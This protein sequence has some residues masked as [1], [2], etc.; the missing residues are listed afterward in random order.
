MPNHN[1]TVDVTYLKTYYAAV[2]YKMAS[3]LQEPPHFDIIESLEGLLDGAAYEFVSPRYEGL[4]ADIKVVKGNIAGKDANVTVTYRTDSFDVIV[5][6]RPAATLHGDA[7]TAFMDQAEGYAHGGYKDGEFYSVENPNYYGFRPFEPVVEGYI[8]GANVEREVRYTDECTNP[9]G[10]SWVVTHDGST[11]KEK[12]E[13]CGIEKA[14]VTAEV[15]YTPKEE[16]GGERPN[17]HYVNCGYCNAELREEACSAAVQPGNHGNCSGECKNCHAHFDYGGE[18]DYSGQKWTFSSDSQ[19]KKTCNR[20]GYNDYQSCNSTSYAHRGSGTSAQHSTACSICKHETGNWQNCTYTGV[21]LGG[22]R[23]THRCVCGRTNG[24]ED[25]H[26]ELQSQRTTETTHTYMCAGCNTTATSSHTRKIRIENRVPATKDTTAS[27]D[28]VTYCSR[29]KYEISRASHGG[30]VKS[31]PTR[32]LTKEKVKDHFRLGGG[33]GTR[34]GRGGYTQSAP[35]VEADIAEVYS[36]A[37]EDYV[38]DNYDTLLLPAENALET[39]FTAHPE[40]SGDGWSIDI[41]PNITVDITSYDAL[42]KS[43]TVDITA[44]YNVY[45]TNRNDVNILIGQ[46]YP[47]AV[48]TPIDLAFNIPNGM[49]AAGTTLY[50]R[51]NHNGTYN[52]YTTTVTETAEAGENAEDFAATK[53]VSFTATAGLSTFELKTTAFPGSNT[54]GGSGSGG[55]SGGGSG[56]GG[57]SGGSTGGSSGGSSKPGTDVQVTNNTDGSTTTTT[58]VTGTDGSNTITAETENK[59]GSK[60]IQATETNADGSKTETTTN[61]AANGDTTSKIVETSATGEVTT[62]ETSK[63][64]DEKSGKVTE[65]KTVTASDGSKEVSEKVTTVTGASTEKAVSVDETGK[66]TNISTGKVTSGGKTTDAD[67]K[68][69]NSSAVKLTEVSTTTTTLT[70]PTA[71]KDL[72]GN[73]YKVTSI[74]K[75]ASK[76]NDTVKTVVIGKNIKTIGAGAFGDCDNLTKVTIGKNVTNIGKG[77]F[78]DSE[79]LK[80]VTI[81][82]TKITKIGAGA[83]EDMNPKGTIYIKG[84]AKQVKRITKLL[85]KSGLPDT[86]KI[87]RV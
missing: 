23:H 12:C 20:C 17:G 53:S 78:G 74:A 43:L 48:G 5:Y 7:L 24:T 49:A 72:D 67:Y 41:Q 37:L 33:G 50:V 83:F 54:G 63:V 79:K 16:V 45:V 25:C 30:K 38:F 3:G 1:L 86:V 68:V 26:Y 65:E 35:I 9:G 40:Y 80:T 19:H 60:D 57:P 46:N 22:G 13:H 84:T 71:I 58:T 42:A 6:R 77:A 36:E 2:H 85:E 8:D 44:T 32:K 4:C 27:F 10:H 47:M 55:Y 70:V 87:K 11:H 29:C 52:Y 56:G 69:T 15:T 76:D 75:N 73:S 28:T 62:T 66:V 34:C 39:F 64:T 51:H 18:H 82:S 61:I 81:E 31:I 59:D 21:K 14:P